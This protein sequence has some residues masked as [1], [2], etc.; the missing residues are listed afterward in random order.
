MQLVNI[1]SVSLQCLPEARSQNMV[2]V[3]KITVGV[4]KQASTPSRARLTLPAGKEGL[5][6]QI[7]VPTCFMLRS[8][9]AKA[10]RLPF[11]CRHIFAS[12]VRFGLESA[13]QQGPNPRAGRARRARQARQS[14]LCGTGLPDQACRRVLVVC[15]TDKH[16]FSEGVR[17][18]PQQRHQTKIFDGALDKIQCS[19]ADRQAKEGSLL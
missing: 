15:A 14:R 9:E 19:H 18:L 10:M 4:S 16:V 1:R 3:S 11:P 12:S 13:P 5:A 2:S 8:F 7:L 6:V 17:R